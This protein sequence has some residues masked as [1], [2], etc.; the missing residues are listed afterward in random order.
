MIVDSFK[1]CVLTIPVDGSQDDLIHCFKK[2]QPCKKGAD[3]LKTQLAILDEPNLGDPFEITESE[4]E[5][6]VPDHLT[7]D[8]SDNSDIDI[9]I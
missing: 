1:Y 7:V 9:D 6:S 8:V 2:N 5:I 3:R 4:R